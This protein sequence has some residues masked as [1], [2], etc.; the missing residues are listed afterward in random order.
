MERAHRSRYFGGQLLRQVRII[1]NMV[2]LLFIRAYERGE[3]VYQSMCARGFD[4]EIRTLSQLKF[5]RWDIVYISLF[6]AA[7]TL[8]KIV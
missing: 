2:G 8:I 1:G 5:K 3:R 4:G 7:I 6:L